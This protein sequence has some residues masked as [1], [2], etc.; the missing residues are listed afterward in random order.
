MELGS[1][2]VP[3]QHLK[4]NSRILQGTI[5][6]KVEFDAKEKEENLIN[7]DVEQKVERGLGEK[8]VE[9]KKNEDYNQL[10]VISTYSTKIVILYQ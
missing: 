2:N 5:P 10:V 3:R 1:I 8:V 7:N 9:E 4:E 6:K